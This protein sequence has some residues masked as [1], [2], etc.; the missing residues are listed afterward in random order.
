MSV[1]KMKCPIS[2]IAQ[3]EFEKLKLR[4]QAYLVL[5]YEKNRSEDDIMERLFID[6]RQT[7]RRMKKRIKVWINVH[8]QNET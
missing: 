5:I 1:P 7:F 4:E 8:Y 6:T 3:A 2:T